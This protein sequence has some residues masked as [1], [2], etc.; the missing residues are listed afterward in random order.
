MV[1]VTRIVKKG[2]PG[3]G[4]IVE[5]IGREDSQRSWVM[6][7]LNRTTRKGNQSSVYVVRDENLV[8]DK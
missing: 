5:V 2:K 8:E 7:K 3:P 1:G 6:E 4:K